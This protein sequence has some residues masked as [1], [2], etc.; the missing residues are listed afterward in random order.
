[1][2]GNG[3]YHRDF[4]WVNDHILNNWGKMG[5]SLPGAKELLPLITSHF[6]EG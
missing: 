1:M 3:R 2:S 6:L 4:C 5:M